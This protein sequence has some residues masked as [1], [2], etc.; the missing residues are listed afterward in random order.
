MNISIWRLK[1]N[2]KIAASAYSRRRLPPATTCIA[3]R[4]ERY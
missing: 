4:A 3:T 2:S 1:P